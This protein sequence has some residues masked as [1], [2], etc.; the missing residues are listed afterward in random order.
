M[1]DFSRIGEAGR[2]IIIAHR[3]AGHRQTKTKSKSLRQIKNIIHENSLEA[4]EKAIEIGADAIEFDLRCTTDGVIVVHHNIHLKRSS[5]PIRELTLDRLQRLAEKRGYYVPTFEETL[6]KL[7]ERIALDIEIKRFGYEQQAIELVRKYYDDK[8]IVFT[9]FVDK[10]IARL[11]EIAP[12]IKCGLLLGLRPPAKI[13]AKSLDPT[14]TMKRIK[15]CKA[16]FVAPHWRLL[17]MPYFA[18]GAVSK[19]PIFAWTV[20]RL[21]VARRLIDYGC[22]AIITDYPER[23]M[24]LAG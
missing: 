24:D 21:P 5:V 19:I 17:K 13:M 8:N 9:S 18:N 6:R 14:Q 11:K 1:I 7:S 22:R 10:T 16:D 2:P 15:N 23:M 20:N 3:G 4:F 12:E